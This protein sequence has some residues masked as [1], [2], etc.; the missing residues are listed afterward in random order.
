MTKIL[1]LIPARGGSKGIPHKNI[2]PLNGKPLIYYSIDIA[3][4]FVCDDDI[5]VSS[6]DC[7]IIS[8]VEQYGLKVPFVRPNEF[9]TDNATTESVIINALN[10][11]KN[12]GV[13]YDV[14]VLLQPTSPFRRVA[15]VRSCIDK[16]QSG[17]YDMVVSV[18]ESTT[19]PY[20]NCYEDDGNGLLKKTMEYRSIARRQDAPKVLEYNGAVYV[21]NAS[22]LYHKKMDDFPH[23]SYCEMER[24]RSLDLDTI[25]DW[26]F[27]EFLL[28]NE[29]NG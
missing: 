28:K 17:A 3:R 5:C 15:D 1:F 20:Y 23:V 16:Y 11:Y 13:N 8:V 2:K 14:V 12:S 22:L 4:N 10:F 7:E 18:M 9:A 27:A 6:D 21:I 29:V 25:L 19:N 26:Q 24:L